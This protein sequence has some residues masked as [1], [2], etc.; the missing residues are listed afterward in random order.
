MVGRM[1]SSIVVPALWFSILF[2][3]IL[4]TFLSNLVLF[5][6]FLGVLF[7]LYLYG[8]GLAI[9]LSFLVFFL[10]LYF[11]YAV[12]NFDFFEAVLE[13][14]YYIRGA[15]IVLIIV[16]VFRYD[17]KAFFESIMWCSVFTSFLLVYSVAAEY[18]GLSFSIVSYIPPDLTERQYSGYTG[19]FNNPNYWAIFAFLNISILLYSIENIRLNFIKKIFLFL[20][21]VVALFSLVGTGSRM[22][23]IVL[24]FSF[25]FLKKIDIK[26]LFLFLVA[27]FFLVNFID[28]YSSDQLGTLIKA[29]E[30]FDRLVNNIEG[31]DRFYR[32]TKYLGAIFSSYQY[33]FFGL[34]LGNEYGIGPPHNTFVLISRDFGVVALFSLVLLYLV[35]SFSSIMRGGRYTPL[36]KLYFLII[37]VFFLTNDVIDSRPFWFIFGVYISLYFDFYGGGDVRKE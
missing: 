27:M 30:R 26:F 35:F 4:G 10:V 28:I 20:A 19:F 8:K 37:P 24:L 5:F 9:N 1:L 22:G 29:Y 31:E 2:S 33:F 3:F 15:V 7:F 23:F 34:G 25:L 21:L 18:L 32:V 11:L 17:S 13:V 16:S 12:V 14:F 36:K 6:C